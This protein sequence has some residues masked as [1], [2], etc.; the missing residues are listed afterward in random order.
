MIKSKTWK[1]RLF[2]SVVAV[3]MIF[4]L[5]PATAMAADSE[6]AAPAEPLVKNVWIGNADAMSEEEKTDQEGVQAYKANMAKVKKV[7]YSKK[8]KT[9]TVLANVDEMTAYRETLE[10]QLLY[11]L[12]MDFGANKDS[13]TAVTEQG[14]QYT[15]N[16]EDKTDGAK[17]VPET[18]KNDAAG[19]IVFWLDANRAATKV[20]LK[21]GNDGTAETYTVNVVKVKEIVSGAKSLVESVYIGNANAMSEEGKEDPTGVKGYKNNMAQVRRAE[22]DFAEGT[23]QVEAYVNKMTNYMYDEIA[24]DA[25]NAFLRNQKLYTLVMD[26]GETD[27]AKISAVG[28]YAIAPEDISG[29]TTFA[30]TGLEEEPSNPIVFWLDAATPETNFFLIDSATQKAQEITVNVFTMAEVKSVT[31]DKTK[32]LTVGDTE[33]LTATV[34]TDPAGENATVTW[35]SDNEAVASVGT[36]GTVTA[37]TA[38]TANIT[39]TAALT[40]QGGQTSQSATCAVTVKAKEEPTT[41]E[42]TTAAKKATVTLNAKTLTMKKGTSTKALAVKKAS[43][44]G[45]KIKS[46]KSSNKKVVA[47]SVKSG[48]TITLKAKKNG[49]ATITVTMKSGAKA[50]VKVTVNNKKV[51]TK[52]ITLSQK[53]ATLKVKKSVKLTVTRNPINATEKITWTSSNKK[54]A[55]VKNGKVVAKKKG[56]ATITAKTANGKKATCKITVKK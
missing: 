35:K 14:G 49:K 4:T 9:I 55:T 20:V 34:V 7:I 17:F 45:D 1:Q 30:P 54:V 50:T 37:K 3:C 43:V 52:K 19:P 31:V 11:T 47:A 10:G 42:P 24:E 51:V 8:A 21:D 27:R 33:K 40:Y 16:P 23:I 53:K 12:V 13:V 56:K 36:D 22:P 44:K 41:Q 26:F 25:P 32:E 18:N 2:A 5:L 39:A 15:F 28:S 46:V 29:G 48:K 38:G 6:G